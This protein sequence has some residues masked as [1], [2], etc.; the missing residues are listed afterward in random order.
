VVTWLQIIIL[1][2]V[3]G[4]T[5]FLPV[6]STGHMIITKEILQMTDSP[7]LN[8][9]LIVVQAGAI[10]AVVTLFWPMFRGWLA[11]WLELISIKLP[12][13][14]NN[15]DI[16]VA[17]AAERRRHSLMIIASV[18]PFALVGFTLRHSIQDLFSSKVVAL[19]LVTGGILILIAERFQLSPKE[20]T[21][22]PSA[23]S[24][25]QALIIG[26]GQCLALWPGFS[27]SAATIV[28][29]RFL[30]YSRSDAAEISFIIGIPTLLGTAGYE[31]IKEFA[32]LD[33][34]WLGFLAV[35]IVTAWLVAYVCVKGFIAFLR[36]YSLATFAYYRILVGMLILAFFA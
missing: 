29:G 22:K 21:L 10:L 20:K 18:I 11:A 5:E 17:S 3:E 25:R 33:S 31:A 9:F 8:A 36:R 19:A 32:H 26:C 6:S 7:A 27:R 24:L 35:G 15:S 2:V 12:A 13:T 28:T 30:G 14:P 16:P 23:M 34:Q 4:I 1:S